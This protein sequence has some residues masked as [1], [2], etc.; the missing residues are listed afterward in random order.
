MKISKS[1]IVKYLKRH[2]K[3]TTEGAK[4]FLSYRKDPLEFMKMLQG[5]DTEKKTLNL[6]EGGKD[7]IKGNRLY[8]SGVTE[9]RNKSNIKLLLISVYGRP[10]YEVEQYLFTFNLIENCP[11]LLPNVV[12]NVEI[13][14][15]V[16]HW[17]LEYNPCWSKDSQLDKRF[18]SR[19]EDSISYHNLTKYL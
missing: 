13:I 7:F 15:Y 9:I 5:I 14:Y 6:P 4:Q 8:I 18:L 12:L 1:R 3:E 10:I 19:I 17:N 16:N 11:I 2:H